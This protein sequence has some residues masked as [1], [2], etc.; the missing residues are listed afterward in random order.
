MMDDDDLLRDAVLRV[1]EVSAVEGR[2]IFVLV[3]Q[4]KNLSDMFLDG[5]ILTNIAVNS[6]VEIR[7]GFLSIIGRVEGE[8]VQSSSDDDESAGSQATN[9]NRRILTVALTGYIDERNVFNG[10]T[11]E[12]PLIGNEAYLLTRQKVHLLHNLVGEGELSI[13]IATL[14]SDD[15]DID[16]PID[17]L[18][19]SHIA[20]FGNTGSGKTNTLASLYQK[21]IEVL[22]QRN[23]H[24]FL[25]RARFIFIDFNGEY[26]TNE[27][28]TPHKVV[29]NLST[30]GNGGDKL[31]FNA[32]G[33]LEIETLSVLVDATEKTQKPF[34]R[35]SLRLLRQVL[36]AGNSD[37]YFQGI[38]KSKVV[39]TLQLADKVK[40]TLLLDYFGQI[41]PDVVDD[42]GVEI[43]LGSDLDWYNV[44]N[45]FRFKDQSVYFRQQPHRIPETIL[46]R[47][48]SESELSED[49]LDNLIA[50][51]YVQ[52]ISDV[53]ANRAQNE[54]VAPMI[55]RLK[56]KKDEIEKLFAF[57]GNEELWS[58]N[59]IV[60][61]L[62]DVNLEM[63]KTI[64]LLLVKRVYREQKESGEGRAL[65][66]IID[67]AH[68]VLSKE[69]A[70][71]AETWKDYRLETF[72]EII[73]EGRKFG[74]FVTLAS[75]RPSDISP[76]I[77]SQAHNYFVHRLV[78]QLDLK[79]I[80]T[81]VSYIDR[82]TEE[83]IPTLPTGTC[84]F[85]GVATQVPLKINVRRLDDLNQP[86]SFT[87]KF[88]DII[89]KM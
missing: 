2:K 60:V 89:P 63:K 77:V 76:T 54:H 82:V 12:L 15:I 56:A 41:L 43:S 21:F 64:P 78:N 36:G 74:V 6:Y 23:P 39:E 55:N 61:N 59:V 25:D 45:E 83:S 75:Q 57:N 3:D 8:R 28:L 11:R 1:G 19:N 85:S 14:F 26:G 79:M 49:L 16:F 4:K 37:A 81:A 68:N 18:F 70:R 13:N 67:E 52:L 9:Q 34:L 51:L 22:R 40:A 31:P 48:S 24:Q 44:G 58:S 69:S 65:T 66:I 86:K 71:E 88:S 17:G 53:L 20:I 62:H 35:R 87:R 46:F 50:V 27:C 33:L 80:S 73:K 5:E 29:Y 7:K 84:I 30:R 42:N 32:D 38:L 47:R 72:E 10:G